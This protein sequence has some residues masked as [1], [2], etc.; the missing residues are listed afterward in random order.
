MKIVTIIGA[1]PQFVKAAVVS[2]AIQ[3]HNEN[4]PG[5]TIQ[6]VLVHT[7]QHYDPNMSEVFFE[8]MHIPSPNY[9]LGIGGG[10]HG[11]MTGQMLAQ[12]E[13][14]LL[15]EK[16]DAV[17]V[18]GDTNST[19]AGALAAIKLHIPV[20]HVEAGL[21]SF[22]IKMP[23]EINRILT[24][25]VSSWLFC[26]TDTAI[27][28]LE[29]EGHLHDAKIS[30][31]GD[32]MYDAALYYRKIAQPTAAVQELIQKLSHG[33]YLATVHRAENTDDPE[34]LRN[35]LTALDRISKNTTVVFPVHPRTRKLIS[36]YCIKLQRLEL[37]DPVGYFDMLTL[38]TNCQGVFTDSGG[39]Q[40]EAYFFQKPCVTLRDETEWVELVENGF[41]KLV[42][43]D[44]DKILQAEHTFREQTLDFNKKLYGTGDAGKTI[45]DLLLHS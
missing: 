42:G 33:F 36:Q 26:P 18:Y 31:V 1:R 11:Q 41:N 24:D 3:R 20:A 16:P 28:N 7:G 44:P 29:N 27:K 23:E 9:H 21:R 14:V 15:Q 12:I 40:K 19:L 34:R 35:I 10:S 30:N 22:N 43:A 4:H 5:Q 38:L 6:E 2:R 37:L 25:R 32:V 45:V 8:E 13:E 39:V 17:L